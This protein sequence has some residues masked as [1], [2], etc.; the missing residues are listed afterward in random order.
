MSKHTK[1]NDLLAQHHGW[2]DREMKCRARIQ[3]LLQAEAAGEVP[4]DYFY[5]RIEDLDRKIQA[6][7]EAKEALRG[8]IHQLQRE[9]FADPEGARREHDLEVVRVRGIDVWALEVAF[10][11]PDIFEDHAPQL[12]GLALTCGKSWIEGPRILLHAYLWGAEECSRDNLMESFQIDGF[13]WSEHTPQWM[14]E[15]NLQS[16][17]DAVYRA[18]EKATAQL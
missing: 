5:A 3:Q 17:I 12:D 4:E 1:L 10:M 11:D 7:E 15:K 14:V 6:A 16:K 13:G 8:P 9:I 2:H 18:I